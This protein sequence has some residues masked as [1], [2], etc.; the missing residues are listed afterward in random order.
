[1]SY[2]IKIRELGLFLRAYGSLTFELQRLNHFYAH[3]WNGLRNINR[4]SA[5]WALLILNFFY[6]AFTVNFKALHTHISG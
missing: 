6:A 2:E 3:P 1:M 5:I 4:H